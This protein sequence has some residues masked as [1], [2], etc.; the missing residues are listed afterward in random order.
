MR[1]TVR[2]HVGETAF[3][4]PSEYVASQVKVSLCPDVRDVTPEIAMDESVG[5]AGAAAFA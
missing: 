2:L 4:E 1:P 3:F 5:F